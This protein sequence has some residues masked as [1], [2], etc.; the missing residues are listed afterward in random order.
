M[1]HVSSIQPSLLINANVKIIMNGFIL[2]LLANH[3][4]ITETGTKFIFHMIPRRTLVSGY[5]ESRESVGN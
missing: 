1:S 3:A 5:P 2:F 4:W